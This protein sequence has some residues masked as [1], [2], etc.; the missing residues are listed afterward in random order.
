MRT[1][2]VTKIL[3]RFLTQ[4]ELQ[5]IDDLY[6]EHS[7]PKQG[8]AAYVPS[9]SDLACYQSW[10]NDKMDI[11]K[12]STIMGLSKATTYNRFARIAKLNA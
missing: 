7:R 1:Q 12:A 8:V 10:L 6:T 5:K 9:P 2:F 4:K 3:Q 11:K